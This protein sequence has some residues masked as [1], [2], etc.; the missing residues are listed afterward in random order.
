[1]NG[2]QKFLRS[3]KI[4]ACKRCFIRCSRSAYSLDHK[5]LGKNW[6]SVTEAPDP[7]LIIWQNIG[8]GKINRCFRSFMVYFVSTLIIF[9]SF[10]VIIYAI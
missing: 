7:T 3:F 6:P 1:M 9:A 4:N 5:Y 10:A 2:K 8:V